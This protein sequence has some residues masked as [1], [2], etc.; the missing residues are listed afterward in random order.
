MGNADTG[1]SHS[2]VSYK[3]SETTKTQWMHVVFFPIVQHF[4]N[5]TGSFPHMMARGKDKLTSGDFRTAAAELIFIVFS[6]SI[7]CTQQ[8]YFH[9]TSS[10]FV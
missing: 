9:S 8:M 2:L 6:N 7:P 5:Q 4:R 1:C 10:L 3:T